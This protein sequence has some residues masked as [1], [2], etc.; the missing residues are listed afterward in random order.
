MLLVIDVGN[1]NTT[2]GVYR[3]EE[4]VVQWRLTT[5]LAGT[6]DEYGVQTRSLFELAGMDFHEI[7]AIVVASVV[8]PLNNTFKGMAEVYFRQTPLFIDHT[9]DTG[10]KILYEPASDVG[11]DR[12]VD[13]VAAVARHGKPCIVVDFGT[14]TTFNAVNNKGEYIG[15][16]IAPGLKIS[17]EALF[18]R[19]SKLPRVEIN[20][21]AKVIGSSTVEAMQS[22]LYFGYASLVDGVLRRMIDEMGETPCIVAT[23]GLA[24]LI[25]AGSKLIEKV[26]DTLTLEGLRLIYR[27][28][29]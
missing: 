11:I 29:R 14:A 7:E 4:L 1:S 25:A 28:S 15:G 26:D 21:P 5:N 3:D 12:I 2:L 20:R 9:T 16:L 22:G 8:P 10:L 6:V 17:A 13:A 24:S 27:R 19:T 23:G 18:S